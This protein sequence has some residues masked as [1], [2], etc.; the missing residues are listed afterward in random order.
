M[1]F[2][3]LVFLII[4]AADLPALLRNKNKRDLMI[5]CTLF[6]LIGTLAVVRSLGIQVPSIL[7][8]MGEAMT[9]IGWTY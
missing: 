4:L 3:I 9:R 1:F 2:V 7:M 6:I 5:Y 8:L